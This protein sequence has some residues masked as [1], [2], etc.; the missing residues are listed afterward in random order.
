MGFPHS[1]ETQNLRPQ[2]GHWQAE[3][4]W[5]GRRFPHRGGPTATP[6]QTW[7]TRA[8]GPF[9]PGF[10]V[11]H[12]SVVP[13]R[14]SGKCPPSAPPRLGNLAVK[15][16][17][18]FPALEATFPWERWTV[19]SWVDKDPNFRRERVGRRE[20]TRD[21]RESGASL[22]NALWVGRGATLT[23]GAPRKPPG[24]ALPKHRKGQKAG[25]GEES[26]LQ[27]NL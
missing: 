17:R 7:D 27:S 10:T 22:Q 11:T 14:P 16:K 18:P 1:S 23:T 19:V 6:R 24:L 26:P 20:S 15:E 5:K 4:V 8:K 12:P 25:F 3:L 9:P 21:G 13:C 2:K